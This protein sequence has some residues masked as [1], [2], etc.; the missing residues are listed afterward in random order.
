MKKEMKFISRCTVA[1]VGTAVFSSLGFSV[2]SGPFALCY[3]I[4]VEG[5]DI[6]CAASVQAYENALNDVNTKIVADFGA[7]AAINPE[8]NI[9]VRV[10]PRDEIPSE[11]ELYNNIAS[12]S[13]KL[14]PC[15]TILHGGTEIAYFS[16]QDEANQAVSSYVNALSPENSEARLDGDF[17]IISSYAAPSEI[18]NAQSGLK[19]MLS[20]RPL[21]VL[22]TVTERIEE[23]IPFTETVS[24]DASMYVGETA[25]DQEGEEGKK[26]TVTRVH[27]K[28]GEELFREL[29]SETTD[30]EPVTRIVRAGTK[31]PPTGIGSGEFI[32]PTSGVISS[33][34]GERWGRNHNG[35]DIADKTGTDIMA[36]DEAS[37]K[38]AGIAS[39]FGNLVILDHGNGYQTYYGHCD[40]LLV[41][42]GD[43][44]EKGAVIAKMGST[45]NSTG[46]HLHFE[47]RRD[48]T[49]CNPL[50]YVSKP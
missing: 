36:A 27:Y 33:L 26:I 15:Y 9:S 22:S 38:F 1:L 41:H 12:L 39:G 28:D 50:D 48:G 2:F 32:F 40:S 5:A 6:G 20:I 13:E 17:K 19:H 35:I 11:R 8:P 16:S 18:M 42:T 14:I 4:S 47:I 43:I 44:V 34:S 29:I 45:G 7:D 3:G 23:S 30:S 21:S 46:P 37:V 31:T 49:I 25:I 10:L 24:N